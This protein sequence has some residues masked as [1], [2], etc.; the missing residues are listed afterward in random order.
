MIT[1][2]EG[3]EEYLSL[4]RGLGFKLKRHGRFV[5]EFVVWLESNV[6]TRITTRLA[7][8]WATE[9]QHLQRAEWAA[10]L[11]AVRA[12]A[13][14][15]STIDEASEVPP[16][17]LLPFRT[18]RTNPYIYSDSEIDRLLRAAIGMPAQFKLQPFT[19]HCLLGLL[20]VTGLR[21]SEAL[22]LESRDLNWEESLLTIRDSKFGKF[23]LVPLH[24]TTKEILGEYA[25]RRD[26]VFPDHP[27]AAFFPSRTGARL[28]RAG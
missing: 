12:F 24:P 27:T 6:E 14:Y 17:G 28:R 19:Y 23:R 3:A 2:R 1:L 20:T 7:L 13:R 26:Q 11:S 18:C 5:R 9:P 15:W 10:R 16:D 8:Q 4:R 25:A 21:I 22:K